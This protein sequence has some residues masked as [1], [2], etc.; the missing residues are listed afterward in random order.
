MTINPDNLRNTAY[1]YPQ[2]AIYK[3]EP[4]RVLPPPLRD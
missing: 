2:S 3:A 4:P 1:I